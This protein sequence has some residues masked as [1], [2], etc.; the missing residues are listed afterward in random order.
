MPTG[1]HFWRCAAGSRRRSAPDSRGR[2]SSRWKPAS[3]G[4]ARQRGPPARV[5]DRTHRPRPQ[6][7]DALPAHLA[8]TRLQE[9]PGRGRTQ[10]LYVRPRVPQSR[11]RRPACPRIHHARMVSCGRALRCGDCG[12]RRMLRLAAETAGNR[13]APS[14]RGPPIRAPRLRGSRSHK[15]SPICGDRSA[16]QLSPKG[17]DRAASPPWRRL[18][19]SLRAPTIPG[20]IYSRRY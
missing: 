18:P 2:A 11:A 5:R 19:V 1:V 14:A 8:R 3:C 15:P 7:H 20:P 4:L 10:D 12:C 16:C 17:N 9:A 6:P 13:F